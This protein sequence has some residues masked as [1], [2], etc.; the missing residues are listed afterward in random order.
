M[1]EWVA[2]GFPDPGIQPTSPVSPAWAGGVFPVAPPGKPTCE[3][4][5]VN[6]TYCSRTDC[7]ASQVALVVKSLPASAG[8][9][10]DTGL[11]PGSGRSPGGENGNPLQSSCLENP[12]GRGSWWATVHEGAESDTTESNVAL[13][14]L[15]FIL[16]TS[17]LIM[18]VC[19]F[20]RIPCW[21]HLVVQRLG[22]CLLIRG[23]RIGP[24]VWEDPVC[25][26][27]AVPQAGAPEPK[28][29]PRCSCGAA[30]A[31]G[32]WALTFVRVQR[33]YSLYICFQRWYNDTPPN[34]KWTV[35]KAR[36]LRLILLNTEVKEDLWVGKRLT[37]KFS[38]LL[39]RRVES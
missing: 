25:W 36:L 16:S 10:R 17:R 6:K 32:S 18:F 7:W 35:R 3:L 31:R 1:L 8:D 13:A 30:P 33:G 19:L 38:P 37:T 4:I 24:L 29:P 26:G 28:E 9:I 22:I 5:C 11:I 12:V 27:A 23:T 14:R 15:W 39:W 34:Q 2:R 20:N 21:T